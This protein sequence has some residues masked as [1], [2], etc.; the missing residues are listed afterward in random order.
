LINDLIEFTNTKTD[1]NQEK[2]K[3]IIRLIKKFLMGF[4]IRQY[5]AYQRKY[6]R[7]KFKY[8][9]WKEVNGHIQPGDPVLDEVHNLCTYPEKEY[10]EATTST[11]KFETISELP[12]PKETK[13]YSPSGSLQNEHLIYHLISQKILPACK[14][15]DKIRLFDVSA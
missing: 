4:Q 15:M 6:F 2:V 12:N 1:N 3:I 10:L 7:N 14:G 9:L 5:A 13:Y 11:A 8:F